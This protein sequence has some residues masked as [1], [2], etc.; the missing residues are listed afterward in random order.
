MASVDAQPART[1][2]DVTQAL[3]ALQRAALKASLLAQQT[4]T[5]LVQSPPVAA[6]QPPTFPV[7]STS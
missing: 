1:P 4:G 2:L 5:V 6:N 3:A 7:Q